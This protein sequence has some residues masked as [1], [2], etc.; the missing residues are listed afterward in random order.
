MC[1]GVQGGPCAGRDQGVAVHHPHEAHLPDRLPWRGLQQDRR[2][3]DGCGP[4][5]RCACGEPGK[6]FMNNPWST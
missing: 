4:Q 6:C 3:P 2:L 1:A 5:G